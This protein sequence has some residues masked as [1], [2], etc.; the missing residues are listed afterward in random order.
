V[1]SRAAPRTA[2]TALESTGVEVI[3][4]AGPNDP[5]RVSSA[6]AQLGQRGITSVLLEGGPRLAGA[7]LDAGEV[8]EMRLFVAPLVLGG[9][10]ARNPMEGQGR[11]SVAEA[12]HALTLDCE[13]LGQDLLISARLREW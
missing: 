13:S 5:A 4:A 10:L 3:V 1:V 11:D 6:L 9:R 12:A 7:F 2:L 8:D